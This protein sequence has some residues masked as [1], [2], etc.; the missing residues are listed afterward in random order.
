MKK[1]IQAIKQLKITTEQPLCAYLYDLE[2]LYQHTKSITDQLPRQCEMFYAVKANSDKK[3]LS[4]LNKT[5]HG[6]EVASLGELKSIK[7]QFP[8]ANIIFGG[9]G[10]TEDELAACLD[11]D[12]EF[13]HV[14]SYFELL[15][16]SHIALKKN[17]PINVLLRLN[18]EFKNLK[19]TRLTMGGK[20]TPFG[21]DEG[22]LKKCLAFLKAH[23]LIAFKGLHFH[24]ISFQTDELNHVDLIDH[25]I[26][27]LFRLNQQFQLD[28]HY[29]NVGG[30]I[31]V[32]Y[33]DKTH[34]FDWQLFFHR[35]KEMLQTKKAENLKLRF[36]C[37]RSLSVYCG[38]YAIEV[39]DIKKTHHQ[40]FA[41]CRGG[42]HHFRTPYAQ[43]HSHPF[44]IVHISQWHHQYQRPQI[45][46]QSISI[47]GQLCTPKDV[48][49][50][51]AEIE[52]LHVGDIIVF[53]HAGAYAWNISH[54]DFLSHPHPDMIYLEND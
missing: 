17:K 7:A 26:D 41:I 35:L 10:K 12:V 51:D 53:S 46:D 31:G 36:E 33:L 30:G 34:R 5:C 9:P 27:Y 39:I 1:I 50:Y 22:E 49:A 4:T 8:Q 43:G 19:Q 45:N 21:M 52:T 16:L 44:E 54:H 11:Y 42:T 37:G 38:F 24:L 40:Y 13:I 32:N 47:V 20:A 48:L 25:Y 14:E 3:L 23:Q 29:L 6:F 28:L 18:I 2:A 15:R